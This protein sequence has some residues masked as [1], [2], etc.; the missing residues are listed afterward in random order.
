MARQRSV[1]TRSSRQKD[2]IKA[3]ARLF[4]AR[5]YHAVGIN[6]I[7]AE[8]GLSGPAIYNHYSSKEALLVAV[9]DDAITSH[10]ES[11]RD[12]VSSLSDPRE[13]LAALI[14]HHL[15]WVFDQC[16]NIVTWRT[17]F[18]NLPEADSQRL[19]YLQR[20]YD[21]E[22]V[23]TLAKLRPELDGAVIRAMCNGAIALLQLPT[24]PGLRDPRMRP[25]YSGLPR[26]ELA[27]LLAKMAADALLGGAPAAPTKSRSRNGLKSG[28]AH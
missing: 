25:L 23:R 9:M 6:E 19:R 16:E 4:S 5:G 27:P 2:F 13:T 3:A 12:L 1:E 24:E 8:L 26:E 17:E 28:A 7:G 20:L 10:L 11:T 14:D 18:R 15:A 22:W 21:D